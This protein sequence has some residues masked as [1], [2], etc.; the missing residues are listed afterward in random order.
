MGLRIV[1][2]DIVDG[3]IPAPADMVKK[4]HYFAGFYT[5]QVVVWDFFHQQYFPEF[6][7]FLEK[8]FDTL[9]RTNIDTKNDGLENVSPFKNGYFGYLG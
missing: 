2:E 1:C 8:N 7:R 5:C 9:P 4:S 6:L 3:R